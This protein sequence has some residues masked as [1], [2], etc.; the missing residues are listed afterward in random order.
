MYKEHVLV[1]GDA[2]QI[3][4][5]IENYFFQGNFEKLRKFSTS[6]TEGIK[7]I[8]SVAERDLGADIIMAGGDDIIL[9]I[10]RD[11]YNQ[12]NI[13]ELIDI[14]RNITSNNISFGVGENPEDAFV[15]LAKAKSRGGGCLVISPSLENS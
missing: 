8:S 15:C 3:R 2:D 9:K 4:L 10:P 5:K 13:L 11:K 12:S 7:E 14:F 6:L 1:I